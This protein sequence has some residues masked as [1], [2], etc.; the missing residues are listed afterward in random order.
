[1]KII[2]VGRNYLD[3]A[4]ELRNEVPQ[5]PVLF[6]KPDTALL[7]Q[8]ADIYLPPFS[9]EVHHEAEI[10][11]RIA[12]MGKH[13]APQFA[14]RYFDHLTLGLDLTARDLQ[15]KL[16]EKGLPWEKAKAFDGSAAVGKWLAKEVLPPLETLHFL[17]LKNGVAVQKG[18]ASDMIFPIDQLIAEIS[19]YFTLK[20]GDLIFTG[21]PAGVG[22][23]QIGDQLELYLGDHSVGQW[24]VK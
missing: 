11:V 7:A 18:A 10:V 3:H 13:I 1:M 4:Q 9:Q 12:K 6:L 14:S 22:P 8:D 2:C 19:K 16:K 15:S 17:L 24:T 20:V 5:E 23:L 21:T